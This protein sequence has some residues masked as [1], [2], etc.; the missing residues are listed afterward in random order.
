MDGAAIDMWIF[1]QIETRFWYVQA[2]KI[3]HGGQ[4][5]NAAGTQGIEQTN[6]GNANKSVT[7]K[8]AINYATWGEG[9]EGKKGGIPAETGQETLVTRNSKGRQTKVCNHRSTL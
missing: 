3:V 9:W 2:N 6:K 5:R 7:G 1:V 4:E 8:H